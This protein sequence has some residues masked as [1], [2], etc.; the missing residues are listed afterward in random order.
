MSLALFTSRGNAGAPAVPTPT[1]VKTPVFGVVE[2]I[3]PGLA[4][5]AE[6]PADHVRLPLPSFIRRVDAAPCAAGRLRE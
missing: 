3:V 6:P 5:S 1:V 2:P 4:Q